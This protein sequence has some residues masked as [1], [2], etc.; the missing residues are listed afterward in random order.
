RAGLA[1]SLGMTKIGAT[2]L[3]TAE[4]LR[5]LAPADLAALVHRDRIDH[6]NSFWRLPGA[7]AAS[8]KLQEIIFA[9]IGIGNNT[10]YHF[11]IAQRRFAAKRDRLPHTG[12]AEQMCFYFRRIHFFSGHINY[13][14]NAT[15]NFKAGAAAGEQIVGDKTAAA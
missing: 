10:C 7:Q 3:F 6:E 8:A 2:P 15:D 4:S 12:K 9:E 14:R 13:V 1:F 5:Q 11:L